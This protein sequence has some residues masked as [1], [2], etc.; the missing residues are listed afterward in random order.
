MIQLLSSEMTV[1]FC[2]MIMHVRGFLLGKETNEATVTHLRQD[3]AA[4]KAHMQT[5]ANRLDRVAFEVESKYHLELQDLKDCLMIEQEEKN[6][7]NKK[8][9]GLE[10]E[11]LI[12]K[13]KRVEQQQ[14]LASSRLVETLKQKIMKLRKENEILKRKLSHSEEG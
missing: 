4:H 5:L 2:V 8:L 6:E 14:D 3:L 9:Q 11:L 7:L 12:S 10:K 1:L 13:T